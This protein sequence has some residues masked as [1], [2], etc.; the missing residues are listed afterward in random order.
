MI[1][2]GAERERVLTPRGLRAAVGVS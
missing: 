1:G 2:T